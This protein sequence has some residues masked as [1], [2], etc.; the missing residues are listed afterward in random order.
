MEPLHD[1][2]KSTVWYTY[3]MGRCLAR[4]HAQPPL[5]QQHDDFWRIYFA[6]RNEQGCSNISDIETM[7]AD[8][9]RSLSHS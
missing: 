5:V 1:T 2:G 8:P 4:S 6:T 9:H 7:L 3:P